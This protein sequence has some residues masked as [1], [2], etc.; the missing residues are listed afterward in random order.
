MTTPKLRTA[1]LAALA[2]LGLAACSSE[3]PPAGTE[4]TPSQADAPAVAEGTAPPRGP[5]NGALPPVEG[6]EFSSQ[7]RE[8]DFAA[9]VQTLASDE[10]EGRAPGGRGEELTINYIREHFERIGLEPGNG[11]SWY[12][13]VPMVETTAAPDTTIDLVMGE[14]TRTLA[15]GSEMVIGTRTGQSTVSVEDSELVFV[16][17]GVNAPE[18]NWNDYEG[19]DV[20][21]KTVVIFVNDPGFHIDSDMFEGERMTYYGRWTYKYEEA[22]R[23]GAA[24]ALIVHDDR[25]AGYGWGVVENSWTGAQFDLPPDVD[26]APRLPL[27]GWISADVA[28]DLFA[29]AGLDLQEQYTAAGTAGFTA[30]PLDAKLNATVESVSRRGESPNVMGLLRGSEKPDEVV[31]YMAHWDHLGRV[32]GGVGDRIYNGAIDN[33]TG[34]AALLEI[35]AQMKAAEEPPKRSVLFLMV[36]LEES[37]LLGSAYYVADPVVP[38]EK[39]VAAI[40]IDAMLPV[41]QTTDFIVVGKGNSELEDILEPLAALQNRTLVPEAAVHAGYYF[42]SDHFNFAKAG[43]PALYAKGGTEHVEHGREHVA[44]IEEDYRVNRYHKPGDHFDPEWDLSGVML[45]L[46]ALYGVGWELA[47]SDRWPNWYEGNPFR[48]A[49]E[50]MMAD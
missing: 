41:G 49:R 3:T 30:V 18:Q 43:V 5:A 44:A 27:Q 36:T 28:R 20:E 38:L 8:E 7:M 32:F 6:H 50:E 15:S 11:D 23:Q 35:A 48:A 24:A 4:T 46:Q 19:L 10:F 17:Y 13:T 29:H 2:G 22:A 16:G 39:T 21:G 26:T 12:Q 37:G 25:G 31:V 45:D 33:A 47:N 34:V 40:N 1:L 14:E 9:H 42:R